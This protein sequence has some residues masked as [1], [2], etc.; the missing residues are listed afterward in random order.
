MNLF[1]GGMNLEM[2]IT[3]SMSFTYEK[4]EERPLHTGVLR[5]SF[6]LTTAL[7]YYPHFI[8][9]EIQAKRDQVT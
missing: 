4:G 3:W 1:A 2:C 6:I 5:I 7:C 8:D 9:V